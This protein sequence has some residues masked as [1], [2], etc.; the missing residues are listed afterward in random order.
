[1][2]NGLDEEHQGVNLYFSLWVCR[3]FVSLKGL[4][5]CFCSCLFVCS[6][7]H[8]ELWLSQALFIINLLWR[9]ESKHRKQFRLGVL[10]LDTGKNSDLLDLVDIP[11]KKFYFINSRCLSHTMAK[12]NASTS[13]LPLFHLIWFCLNFKQ[14]TSSTYFLGLGNN[15]KHQPFP[16]V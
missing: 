8:L 11:E 7:L 9:W 5:V 10:G 3:S 4:F 15:T 6:T 2:Q 12:W 13:C 1:M 14:P 16:L